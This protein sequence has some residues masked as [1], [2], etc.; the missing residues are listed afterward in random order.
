MGDADTRARR[1][2][3]RLGELRCDALERAYALA[4][5]LIRDLREMYEVENRQ[6]LLDSARA[7]ENATSEPLTFAKLAAFARAVSDL[8]EWL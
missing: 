2:L 3:G 6:W 5:Q 7:L 8:R 4:P 1:T